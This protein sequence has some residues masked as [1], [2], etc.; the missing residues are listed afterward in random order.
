MILSPG[1]RMAPLR[2][3]N[4]VSVL[5]DRRSEATI[6]T[7]AEAVTAAILERPVHGQTMEHHHVAALVVGSRPDTRIRDRGAEAVSPMPRVRQESTPM[8]PRQHRQ[9]APR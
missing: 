1:F 4:D 3:P 7:Q 6:H 2:Q 8:G 9:A 5:L